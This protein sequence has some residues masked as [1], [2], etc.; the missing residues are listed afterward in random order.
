M[1]LGQN[2]M[3]TP[4]PTPSGISLFPEG[5]MPDGNTGNPMPQV[6]TGAAITTM[7]QNVVTPQNNV[8]QTVNQLGTYTYTASD[9][10]GFVMK[11]RKASDQTRHI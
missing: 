11:T 7:G 8:G 9:G 10:F 2:G 6:D 5:S 4:G 1:A 3:A